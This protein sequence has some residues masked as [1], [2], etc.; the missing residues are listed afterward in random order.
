MGTMTFDEC[1]KIVAF[2]LMETIGNEYYEQH[3][4]EIEKVEFSPEF[5][6][7]MARLFDSLE[8]KQ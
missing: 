4:E 3:K 6:A 2:R 1:L 7:R 8:V 5:E